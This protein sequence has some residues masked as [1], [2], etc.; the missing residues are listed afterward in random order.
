MC[1]TQV[2]LR[3]SDRRGLTV[4][5]IRSCHHLRIHMDRFSA[6]T[7]SSP[8]NNQVLSSRGRGRDGFSRRTRERLTPHAPRLDEQ[9]YAATNQT[10]SELEPAIGDFLLLPYGRSDFMVQVLS[11]AHGRVTVQFLNKKDRKTDPTSSF[12]FE[13]QLEPAASPFEFE[14]HCMFIN[15]GRSSGWL[16]QESRASTKEANEA[17]SR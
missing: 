10:T 12:E 15:N 17:A 16:E 11:K 9:P 4:K 3:S 2:L 14:L 7:R 1:G 8:K 6:K 13:W 5:S